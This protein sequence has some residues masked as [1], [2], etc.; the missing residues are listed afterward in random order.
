MVYH[1]TYIRHGIRGIPSYRYGHK[2]G[3]VRMTID[4]CRMSIMEEDG[5]LGQVFVITIYFS[6][7]RGWPHKAEWEHCFVCRIAIFGFFVK[8]L[9]EVRHRQMNLLSVIW[10]KK[11]ANSFHFY[12]WTNVSIISLFLHQHH[13]HLQRALN[14]RLTLWL[15]KGEGDKKHEPKT[16]K[17]NTSKKKSPESKK[18][19]ETPLGWFYKVCSQR[20]ARSEEQRIHVTRSLSHLLT[21]ETYILPF[22]IAHVSDF[23]FCILIFSFAPRRNLSSSLFFF[24]DRFC[25]LCFIRVCAIRLMKAFFVSLSSSSSFSSFPLSSGWLVCFVFL[26]FRPCL[27]KQNDKWHRLQQLLRTSKMS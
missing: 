5:K 16:R 12:S 8:F 21:V 18:K 3:T 6:L 19:S 17:R 4:D 25:F 10:E 26:S 23:F 2:G 7:L 11:L 1:G 9:G 27:P 22:F 14:H 20:W 13:V 24:P 15:N